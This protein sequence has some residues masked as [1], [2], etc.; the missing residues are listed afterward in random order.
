[1]A[2]TLKQPNTDKLKFLQLVY[3]KGS[4]NEGEECI[5]NKLLRGKGYNWHYHRYDPNMKEECVSGLQCELISWSKNPKSV[6]K[7][8]GN[9]HDISDLHFFFE[10]T[11]SKNFYHV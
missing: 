2:I 6:C 10:I 11:A 5:N 7:H 1:M 3:L 4:R 9:L 8:P